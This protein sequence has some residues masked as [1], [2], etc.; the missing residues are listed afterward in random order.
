MGAIFVHDSP[1]GCNSLVFIIV[2]HPL[3]ARRTYSAT[4]VPTLEVLP[5]FPLPS[6]CNAM[7]RRDDHLSVAGDF[8][9]AADRLS[10]LIIVIAGI[11][12]DIS[13]LDFNKVVA[14]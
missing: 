11:Y 4:V 8:V 13:T 1:L 5:N 9:V 12:G 2:T 10:R 14:G 3:L 7:S 6:E